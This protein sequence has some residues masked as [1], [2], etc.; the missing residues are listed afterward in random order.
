MKKLYVAW[1]ELYK[2]PL[3]DNHR[4]P[5]LKYELLPEQ[6]VYEGVIEQSNFF[7]PQP[8][9]E[10]L[11]LKVHNENYWNRLHQLEL[12]KKEQRATGF[13]HSHELIEREITIMGGT[14][15]CAVKALENGI[16][17]NIAGGTHHAYTDRGE[18]FCLLNDQ[19]LASR[20]LLDNNKASKI[21]IIDLDVHQGNGTAEI[22]QD[23]PEVF[24]FSMHGANNYP[25]R[26]EISD[27]D[28]PLPDGI[29]DQEYLRLLTSSLEKIKK[30]FTPDFIF[31]QCGVDI[32]ETDKLGRLSVSVAG[33]KERDRR[34]FEF[35]QELSAPVVCSMGGGYSEDIKIIVN[36]HANTFKLAQDIFY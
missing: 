36:A 30:R 25:L 7:S 5:M 27:L 3:P 13:P 22:F 31:Y 35:A 2:H 20:Y 26:K 8:I 18:G 32:L 14:V 17:M 28:V 1:N 33:C 11:I 6:L 4:F 34:V 9:N 23:V 15:E 16:S 10:E 24:T 19:A 21:L 29:K 12:S